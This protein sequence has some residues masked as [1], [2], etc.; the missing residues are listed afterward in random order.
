MRLAS[1]LGQDKDRVPAR[2]AEERSR[3]TTRR[4]C[5][6]QVTPRQWQKWS[7]VSEDEEVLFHEEKIPEG[8]AVMEFL[9]LRRDAASDDDE[10]TADINIGR[11]MMMLKSHGTGQYSIFLSLVK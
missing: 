4:E 5:G 7:A 6:W 10:E 1:E 9:K 3:E 11:M 8:S 2:A